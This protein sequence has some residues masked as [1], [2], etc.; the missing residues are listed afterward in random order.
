M[1]IT[2]CVWWLYTSVGLP[3]AVQHEGSAKAQQL[4]EQRKLVIVREE[5]ATSFQAIKVADQCIETYHA[6][7]YKSNLKC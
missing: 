1:Q 5:A 3:G 2:S 6:F 7:A 4:D